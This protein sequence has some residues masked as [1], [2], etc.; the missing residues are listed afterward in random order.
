MLNDEIPLLILSKVTEDIKAFKSRM[1]EGQVGLACYDTS[2]PTA[3][4]PLKLKQII[5]A[6]HPLR[7]SSPM[8][9]YATGLLT[10][11]EVLPRSAY[12]SRRWHGLDNTPFPDGICLLS[13]SL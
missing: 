9:T 5:S 11:V 12:E 13:G 7:T 2:Q 6:S 8:G 1:P 10:V 4:P 3:A